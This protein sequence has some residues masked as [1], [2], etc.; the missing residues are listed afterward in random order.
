MGLI[1]DGNFRPCPFLR[2]AHL[3]TIWAAKCRKK[4]ILKDVEWEQLELPDGDFLELVWNRNP[5]RPT[6]AILSGLEGSFQKSTYLQCLMETL[7]FNNMQGVLIHFRGCGREINRLP[8]SYHAGDTSDVDFALQHI[9]E[10]SSSFPTAIIGYSLGGNVLLR[11][12]ALTQPTLL[13]TAIAI[14]VPFDLAASS[15]HLSQGFSRHYQRYLLKSM[16][17]KFLKKTKL[18]GSFLPIKDI[19]ALNSFRLF[20]DAVTAPLHGFSG[21]DDYYKKASCLNILPEVR[22][23]T[24]IIHALDD[25]FLPSEALPSRKK[26]SKSTT[27]ELSTHGGHV[28]FIGATK[29]GRLD[30]WLEDRIVSHIESV[31]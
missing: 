12:L 1:L 31:L 28:G 10:K 4:P 19:N 11:W 22:T 16:Q 17:L 6:V 8:K 3:Q 5:D 21:V 18:L 13:K 2:G 29:F 7:R 27:I 25:P 23:K 26:I 20:D 9:T 24:L 30:Y 15:H 14:S